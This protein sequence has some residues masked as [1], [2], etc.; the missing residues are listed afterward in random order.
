M[1]NLHEFNNKVDEL[2]EKIDSDGEFM[3]YEIMAGGTVNDLIT[4]LAPILYKKYKDSPLPESHPIPV[5]EIWT[6][7]DFESDS[8]VWILW[9]DKKEGWVHEGKRISGPKK[10]ILDCINN[11]FNMEYYR[12]NFE[13]F[14][15]YE[16]KFI[17][18]VNKYLW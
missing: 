5:L 17:D 4:L 12:H 14:C 16:K 2:N 18:L 15:T 11:K 3:G 7:D 9:Y 8:S 6:Y 13:E 10:F 1:N